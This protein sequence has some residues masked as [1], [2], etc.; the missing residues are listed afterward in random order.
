MLDVYV[1]VNV[2]YWIGGEGKSLYEENGIRKLAFDAV[3]VSKSV[4]ILQYCITAT[5]TFYWQFQ[6][7]SLF[8]I[9]R[10]Y[11]EDPHRP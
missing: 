10:Y 3:E 11:F 2:Q 4:K 1:D 9:P 8:P 5:V 7:F 6:L